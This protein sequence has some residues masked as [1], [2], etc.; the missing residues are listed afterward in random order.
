MV[1][2]SSSQKQ[3]RDPNTS[4]CS[5]RQSIRQEPPLVV[6]FIQKLVRDVET[7]E[8]GSISWCLAMDTLLDVNRV[9][10]RWQLKQGL[11]LEQKRSFENGITIRAI[12]KP[13]A[14]RQILL[15]DSCQ[16]LL[17]LRL[18][19]KRQ[20]FQEGKQKILVAQATG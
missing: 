12:P 17:W 3:P 5:T 7:E 18:R 10:I 9:M 6:S 2:A 8:G 4:L 15:E 16:K 20:K 11:F 19:L 1:E 13:S 14:W